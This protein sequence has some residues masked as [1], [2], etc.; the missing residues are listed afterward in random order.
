MDM[1]FIVR[2]LPL[3]VEAAKLTLG[4]GLVGIALSLLVGLVIACNQYFKVPLLRQLAAVYI[5]LSRNTPLLVQLFFLYFGLPKA[6]IRLSSEG[7]AVIGL[8]FLGGNY[9]AEAFRSGFRSGSLC[10]YDLSD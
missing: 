10:Q 6:G 3:Y 9:M 1:E 4:I 5:E 8:C 7:C 2:Y